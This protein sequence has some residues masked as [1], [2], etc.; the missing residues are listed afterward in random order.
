MTSTAPPTNPDGVRLPGTQLH[1]FKE[2]YDD[3]WTY[4][5]DVRLFTLPSD[6]R[7]TFH[8]FCAF[9]KIESP[10]PVQGVIT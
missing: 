2:G 10:P 6:P 4:P 7:K 9:C 5:V 8:D 3:R 1:L